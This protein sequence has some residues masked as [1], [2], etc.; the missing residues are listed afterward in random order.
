MVKQASVAVVVTSCLAACASTGGWPTVADASAMSDTPDHFV[1]VD[2]A[3]GA[4]SEP[5]G[6]ASCRNPL[7]DPR[8]GA[9]LT[10]ERSNGGFGDYRPD[11]PRYGLGA[12][13]LLRIDCRSGRAVGVTQD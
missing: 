1:V 11:A 8:N 4:T 13:Q 9:R 5:S 6:E 10:L 3:S 12:D 2:A 7:A